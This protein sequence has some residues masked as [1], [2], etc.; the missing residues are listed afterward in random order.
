MELAGRNGDEKSRATAT[1]AKLAWSGR[2]WDLFLPARDKIPSRNVPWISIA[3]ASGVGRKGAKSPGD[4][5]ATRRGKP[6]APQTA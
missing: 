3:Y 6:H 4:E 2:D 5:R 1:A